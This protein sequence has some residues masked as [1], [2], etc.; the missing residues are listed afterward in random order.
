VKRGF[1]L[2][3]LPRVELRYRTLATDLELNARLWDVAPDGTETLVDR[4]AYRATNPDPTGER[5]RFELFGAAW[6]FRAGH[7]VL[8]EVVQDDSTFLRRD[9][10]ASSATIDGGR[11]SMP[12][13]GAS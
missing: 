2:I 10:F 8:L 4:G 6:R 3:G 12:T 13:R 5:A 7:R 1:T 11:L 9:N